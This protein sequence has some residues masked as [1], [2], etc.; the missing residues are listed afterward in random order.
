MRAM[1]SLVSVVAVVIFTLSFSPATA[2]TQF[3]LKPGATGEVCLECHATFEETMKMS[4]VH[5]PVEGGSCTGCHNPHASS[6]GKLLA[7]GRDEVC[8]ECHEGTLPEAARSA[9]EAVATGDCLSCHDAHATNHE[10]NLLRGGNDLC[11]EC[12]AD[13]AKAV[14]NARFKHN[15]VGK[16]CLTCHDPHASSEAPFLLRSDEPGLCIECHDPNGSSFSERHMNYPV[17]QARC[18]SCHDPHGSDSS[19]LLWA[20]VHRPVVNKMCNQCHLDSSSP[21]ALQTKSSGA[22]MCRGCH[23]RMLNETMAKESL[24]WP[25]ADRVSC[26][27]CHSPHA[28]KQAGLLAGPTVEVCGECHAD[29][30]ARQQRSGTKHE[31]ASAGECTLCHSPHSSNS[32]FLLVS[33]GTIELCGQCHDWDSHSTHP[34]G[35]KMVDLRNPNLTLDCTSCHLAHGSEHQY[36]SPFDPAAELCVDCHKE[37]RR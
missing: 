31:P 14:S 15:P 23:N 30:L 28:S 6:H 33:D 3:R 24:H 17:A 21:D 18:S 10:N 32:D 36:L 35:E 8:A 13:V 37:M 26:Q 34:I 27:H 20:S 11:N 29:T 25:I 16:S 9:H 19:G 22:E 12:H 7:T 1:S 5:T 2:Q 4:S